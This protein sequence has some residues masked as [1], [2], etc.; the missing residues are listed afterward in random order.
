MV[1]AGMQQRT[2]QISSE[3]IG[4]GQERACYLHPEDARKVVKINR[5]W[6]RFISRLQ[7]YSAE[8]M[9]DFEGNPRML[10]SAYRKSE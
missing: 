8:M 4:V 6:N 10:D 7:H 2:L 1:C 5:P 3:A 9:R